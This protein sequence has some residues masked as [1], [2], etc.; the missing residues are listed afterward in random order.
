MDR[1][2]WVSDHAH[3]SGMRCKARKIGC[4]PATGKFNRSAMHYRKKEYP[5]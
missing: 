3:A 4:D 5:G 1:L 2:R